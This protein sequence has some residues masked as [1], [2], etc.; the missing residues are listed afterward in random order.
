M[1]RR[2]ALGLLGLICLLAL[3][4]VAASWK[5]SSALLVPAQGPG[6]LS[7]RVVA[8]DEETIT[9]E[10]SDAAARPGIYGMSWEGGHA[11][12]G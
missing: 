3:A 6:Q 9:L 5:L 4:V 12:V 10:R 8:V 1:R 7:E 11:I 2:L